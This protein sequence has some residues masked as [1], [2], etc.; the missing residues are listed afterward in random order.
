MDE[1][2]AVHDRLSAGP[3][4]VLED[5]RDG[6][7]E[8]DVA[9]RD[10]EREPI[11]GEADG[12]RVD[13]ENRGPRPDTSEPRLHTAVPVQ[14]GDLGPFVQAKPSLEQSPPEPEAEPRG[15]NR[16]V[17]PLCRA[18]E[19]ERRV[20]AGTHLLA[21]ER[22]DLV[23]CSERRACVHGA[24]P[25]A[26]LRL[27][28]RDPQHRRRPI[29]GVD[30]VVTTPVADPAHGILR[31]ATDGQRRRVASALAERLDVPPE[32]LAEASVPP[33]RAVST[34]SRLEQ[35]DLDAGLEN[36]QVP[37]RP[38]AEVPA[39]DDDDI[40]A[41]VALERA[42][43][44]DRAGLLE[45]PPVTGVPDPLHGVATLA[46]ASAKEEWRMGLEATTTGTTTLLVMGREE[47][48]CVD[49]AETVGPAP[50]PTRT[51][52][53]RSSPVVAKTLPQFQ[54]TCRVNRVNPRLLGDTLGETRDDLRDVGQFRRALIEI[55]P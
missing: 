2:P 48:G 13:R 29:P 15:L 16:R 53:Q 32:R 1:R 43:R 33:A 36:E 52:S 5:V 22:H 14:P 17:Q 9:R 34:H 23:I 25:R 41:R 51:T 11:A 24:V 28:R 20:A 31:R 50:R 54:A 47:S 45:P 37:R 3:T 30:L 18:A 42:R 4:E 10:G 6:L 39:A 21:R 7:R 46:A 8:H 19:E 35:R 27:R 40:R 12:C 55:P 44:R 49:L 38:E 26:E